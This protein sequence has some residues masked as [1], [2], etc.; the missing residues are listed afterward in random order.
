MDN[1]YCH[2]KTNPSPPPPP[3]PPHPQ[4]SIKSQG[5]WKC[6]V[7]GLA[8]H[9]LVFFVFNPPPSPPRP[10]PL[11]FTIDS[12]V[13]H[14]RRRPPSFVLTTST[15]VWNNRCACWCDKKPTNHVE[16]KLKLSA[17]RC[18]QPGLSGREY[19]CDCSYDYIGAFFMCKHTGTHTHAL[20]RTHTHTQSLSLSL[21]LVS[22]DLN[23]KHSLSR[24]VGASQISIIIIK[25]NYK[26]A[27]TPPPPPPTHTHTIK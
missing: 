23:N 26:T 16:T 12:L 8:V 5:R 15:T 17:R 3:P 4:K 27:K 2:C 14:Q 1:N 13:T 11:T 25:K 21:S 10:H 24:R 22:Q 9:L 19:Y 6:G 7:A 18:Q 20:A